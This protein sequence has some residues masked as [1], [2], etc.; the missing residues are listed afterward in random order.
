MPANPGKEVALKKKKE[1]RS[2]EGGEEEPKKWIRPGGSGPFKRKNS[3]GKGNPQQKKKKKKNN[4]GGGKGEKGF[5]KKGNVSEKIHKRGSRIHWKKKG[6][7]Y[8]GESSVRP[9]RRGYWG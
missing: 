3:L 6:G 9:A 1:P 8:T 5:R 7:E 2:T 4:W